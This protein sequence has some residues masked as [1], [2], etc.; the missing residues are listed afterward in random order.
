MK[1]R[2]QE[3]FSNQHWMIHDLR[4]ANEI[5]DDEEIQLVELLKQAQ[6]EFDKIEKW[7]RTAYEWFEDND[8]INVNSIAYKELE[9]IIKELK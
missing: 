5:Y 3:L 9:E 8:N 4:D 2:I 6:L 7:L 1:S